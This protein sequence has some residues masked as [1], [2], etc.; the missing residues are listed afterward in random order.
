MGGSNQIEASSNGLEVVRENGMELCDWLVTRSG[1]ERIGQ[2]RWSLE[3]E[4]PI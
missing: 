4:S 1:L 2:V 3:A